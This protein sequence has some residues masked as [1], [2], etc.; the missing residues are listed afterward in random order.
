MAELYEK[1]TLPPVQPHYK[2]YAVWREEEKCTSAAEKQRQYWL[3]QYAE[4][5]EDLA[6]PLW[7]FRASCTVI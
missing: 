7:I 3:E 5:P 2:D 4:P 6:L 1:K